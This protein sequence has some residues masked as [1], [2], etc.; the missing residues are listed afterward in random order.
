MRSICPARHQSGEITMS[1]GVALLLKL[2]QDVH[3]RLSGEYLVT[4]RNYPSYQVQAEHSVQHRAI[5]DASLAS[6]SIPFG[7]DGTSSSESATSCAMAD[8]GSVILG[9]ATQGDW[10]GTNKGSGDFMAVALRSS[11]GSELWRWQVRNSQLT[12]YRE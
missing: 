9:G 6:V 8:D 4:R 5:R 2:H 1:L 10:M 12:P 3:L 11:D 7:Q